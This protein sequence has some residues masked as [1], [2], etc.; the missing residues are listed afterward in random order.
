MNSLLYFVSTHPIRACGFLALVFGIALNPAPGHSQIVTTFA[1]EQGG[2]VSAGQTGGAGENDHDSALDATPS[3]R[4]NSVNFLRKG[5]ISVDISALPANALVTSATFS[6]WSSATGTIDSNFFGINDGVA[7]ENFTQASITFD[8]AP[9]NVAYDGAPANFI[10][11]NI[12]MNPGESFEIVDNFGTGVQSGIQANRRVYTVTF[13]GSDLDP[14]NNDTN[15]IVTFA[16]T[17]DDGVGLITFFT[18][19][20]AETGLTLTYTIVPE[21]T[22]A[23][24]L[25]GGLS[26]LALRRRQR[27]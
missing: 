18:D 4:G 13:S 9:G 11:N 24:M 7:N 15:G 27:N 3:T 17:P 16:A 14:I 12:G 10:D 1:F 25:L 23:A 19:N 6:I 8:N 22:S 5:F 21:P 20:N 26:L 2:T